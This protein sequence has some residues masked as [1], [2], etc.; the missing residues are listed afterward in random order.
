MPL[1]GSTSAS[2]W[3]L[4][5]DSDKSTP[6]R[7]APIAIDS[8]LTCINNA[9]PKT[10]NSAAAVITSLAFAAASNRNNGLSNQYP[11]AINP[12]IAIK[13]MPIFSKRAEVLS[14]T[15]FG[16]INATIVSNGTMSK[17]SNNKMATIF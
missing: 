17:S 5:V 7:K 1:N 15:W 4:N 9:A 13:P 16:A 2:I 8:P 11:A 6:A 14:T 3:C 12:A 10:T